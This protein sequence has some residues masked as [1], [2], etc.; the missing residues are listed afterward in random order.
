[1]NPNETTTSGA[2]D[3]RVL[4]TIRSQQRWLKALTAIAFSFWL[5]TVVGGI[6]I[7]VCY[8][9]F[10]QPKERQLMRDM[11]MRQQAIA[12]GT[13]APPI[14]AEQVMGIQT[15]MSYVIMKGVLIVTGC[16]LLLSVGTVL[17]LVLVIANRRVTLKQINCNLAQISEQ[18]KQLQARSTT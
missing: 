3:G 13:N 8:S 7:L 17:T 4:K 2:A 9:I 5:L 14:T 6:T 15:T 11:E 18:L 12:S 10:I 16:L 1:M